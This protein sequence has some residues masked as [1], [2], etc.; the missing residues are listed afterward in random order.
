M[1]VDER[2]EVASAAQQQKR[3]NLD[4]LVFLMAVHVTSTV[5][6][7]RIYREDSSRVTTSRNRIGLSL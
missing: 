6:S 2:D 4:A 3:R 1:H 7:A 5:A